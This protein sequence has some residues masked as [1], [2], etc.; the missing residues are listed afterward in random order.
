MGNGFEMWRLLHVENQGGEDAIEFGGVRRLQEF[1]RCNEVR[2]LN[3]HIDDWLDVLSHYGAELEHCPRL[4][5]SMVFS[6]IA[7]SYE[8]E[9]L[10]KPEFCR[11]YTDIIKWCRMKT[12][13]IRTR[14]L[15]ELSRKPH[16]AEAL[17]AQKV[18]DEDDD[19]ILADPKRAPAAEAPPPPPKPEDE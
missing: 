18:Y 14:E 9:L 17:R 10:T 4:L 8:D 6:I 15:A 5:K 13:I 16:H 1:P 19:E 3:E 12:Q 2:H 7:K 11:S